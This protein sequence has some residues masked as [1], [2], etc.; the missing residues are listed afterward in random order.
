MKIVQKLLLGLGMAFGAAML[1]ACGG[2][3]TPGEVA[4]DFITNAYKGNGDA[5]IKFINIPEQDAKEGVKEMVDGKLKAQ[6]AR[7]KATAD[8]KGGLKSIEIVK[9]ETSGDKAN[10]ELKV[11]FA[12]G[13]SKN[14]YLNLTKVKD[15][16]KLELK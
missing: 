8:E 1:A 7:T 14:E 9:E 16:W 10:V 3:D 4:K 15:D 5:L 2:G 13:S 11:N 12:D 6:S